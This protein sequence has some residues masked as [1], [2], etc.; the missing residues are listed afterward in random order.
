M[1]YMDLQDG[2]KP[3]SLANRRLLSHAV[4]FLL[5]IYGAYFTIQ[6]GILSEVLEKLLPVRFLAEIFAGFL[7]TSFL[8]IPLSLASI[9][10][11]SQ[12]GNPIQIALLGGLGAMTADLIIA[13][14]FRDSLFQD[15]ST[16]T[17]DLKLKRLFHFA[18]ASY[19]NHFAPLIGILI[20]ASPLPDEAGIVLLSVS[21][22]KM[23]EIM[24][25]TYLI[26]AI[27]IFIISA[28]IDLAK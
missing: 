25:I 26:N 21:K 6:S 11:L 9:Y 18:K 16:L 13:K 15:V 14:I 3:L 10:V 24:A 22:L 20:I 28:S 7:F 19:F 12:D 17:R 1:E 5:S 8:T 27:G 23:H 4:I 2:V